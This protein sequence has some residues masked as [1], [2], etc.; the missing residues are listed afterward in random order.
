MLYFPNNIEDV[1]IK[2][3][4]KITLKSRW[5]CWW[6][7]EYRRSWY[8]KKKKHDS[9]LRC[10]CCCDS[11]LWNALPFQSY[12]FI[13]NLKYKSTRRP[14][15]RRESGTQVR[16]W[17]ESRLAVQSWK[18]ERSSGLTLLSQFIFQVC[19]YY[20]EYKINYKNVNY[21]FS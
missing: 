4:R 18:L 5:S 6:K 3:Q 16:C 20:C 1:E 21:Y 19:W 7:S 9:S 11:E 14:H 2:Q 15:H 17:I 12:F 10:C 8:L 13:W